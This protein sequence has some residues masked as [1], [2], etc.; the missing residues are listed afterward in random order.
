M[1]F[2]IVTMEIMVTPIAV[3]VIL[4]VIIITAEIRMKLVKVEGS[5][6]VVEEAEAAGKENNSYHGDITAIAYSS[7]PKRTFL[8]S[9]I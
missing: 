2:Q 5:I 8:H 4:M 7:M 3:V 1:D 9:F 6:V